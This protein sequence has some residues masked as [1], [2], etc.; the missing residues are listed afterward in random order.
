MNVREGIE[1]GTLTI[2]QAEEM[3]HGK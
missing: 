1:K 3:Y 2:K